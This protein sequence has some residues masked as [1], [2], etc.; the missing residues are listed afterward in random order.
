MR[1]VSSKL[2][3]NSFEKLN[4]LQPSVQPSQ[5][6]VLCCITSGGFCAVYI[7]IRHWGRNEH[8]VGGYAQLEV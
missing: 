8:P 5:A 2:K 1:V 4:R 3:W 7:M 6:T